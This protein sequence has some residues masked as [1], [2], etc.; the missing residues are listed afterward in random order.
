MITYSEDQ[1]SSWTR[2][3]SWTYFPRTSYPHMSVVIWCK[4]VYRWDQRLN[5]MTFMTMQLSVSS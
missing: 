4:V 3:F 1:L 2:Y 5:T